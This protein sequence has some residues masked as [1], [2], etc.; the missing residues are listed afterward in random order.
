MKS[1]SLIEIVWN[2]FFASV[3]RALRHQSWSV[4]IRT[5]MHSGLSPDLD[6]IEKECITAWVLVS[7]CLDRQGCV[8]ASV[9]S[10]PDQ[11]WS[12]Q[13][14]IPYQDWGLAYPQYSVH[15]CE[16]CIAWFRL[17]SETDVFQWLHVLEWHVLC[18][19]HWKGTCHLYHVIG[20]HS[21]LVSI[22]AAAVV[23][24]AILYFCMMNDLANL[25][26]VMEY[27]TSVWWID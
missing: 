6:W 16:I 1:A 4:H 27:R 9:L 10:R 8:K 15:L 26:H 25:I 2:S 23:F 24:Y 21:L 5:G 14:R 17:L 20:W 3:V 7:S 11:S 18:I 19:S 12:G 22:I 13:G